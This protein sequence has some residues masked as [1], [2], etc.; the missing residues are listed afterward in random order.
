MNAAEIAK[1]AGTD[2]YKGG[3][4]GGGYHDTITLGKD[5]KFYLA[6]YSQL[7]TERA[8]PICL[9]DSVDV[10]FLK[11]RSKLTRW[12]DNK[13]TLTSV[14]Y[15][16]EAGEIATSIGAM[17]EKEA[18]ASGAKKALV[19]YALHEGK[20]VKMQVAGGSLY[21]PDD[22]ENL[23]LYSYMQSFEGDDHTFMSVTKIAAI[24]NEYE[25]EGET[26]KSFHMCF[27]K[28]GESNLEKVGSSLEALMAE[29]EENDARDL[30]FIGLEKKAED[31]YEGKN[32]EGAEAVDP[33]VASGKKPF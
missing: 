3:H 5:G 23:R 8:D 32:E 24:E 16:A 30:K 6:Y 26:K 21:N 22:E 27:A 28:E 7:K 12:E 4:V 19:I 25:W 18:K 15:D 20:L 11:V 10:T 17:T 13:Q 1:M 2:A 9:G 29:L 33:D 31:A 14:E